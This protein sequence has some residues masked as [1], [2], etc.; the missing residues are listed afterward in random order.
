MQGAALEKAKDRLTSAEARLKDLEL[1]KDYKSAR[2]CW[3]EFLIASNSVFS[4]LQ[5]G[6]KGA[7]KSQAWFAKKVQLRK[8][9]PLLS[10]LHH[11]R[12]AEEH[13]VPSVTE[14]DRQKIVLVEA[15][16]PT[17]AIE[18]MVGNT[19]T[20]RNLSDKPLDPQKVTELRIYPDRATCPR[21]GSRDRI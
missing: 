4:V 5:Q 6:A 1:A 13:N 8:S 17:A 9:D 7:G 12:N 3:Y 2:R 10:Y 21:R 15:D 20:F 18:E 16:K 11:A 19:G 14:L